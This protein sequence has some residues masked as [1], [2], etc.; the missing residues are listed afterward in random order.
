M[1]ES[2]SESESESE[3]ERES[4]HAGFYK[5][6]TKASWLDPTTVNRG[7]F[8]QMGQISKTQVRKHNATGLLG[9]YVHFGRFFPPFN[10][11]ALLSSF[12][13]NY[14]SWSYEAA[15]EDGTQLILFLRLLGLTTEAV[16]RIGGIYNRAVPT[17]ALIRKRAAGREEEEGYPPP[18]RRGAGT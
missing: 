2:E 13:V 8:Y 9:L 10:N 15:T 6:P 1:R 14:Y 7:S 12:A 5:P 11:R 16:G 4:S 17:S 3:R 18:R